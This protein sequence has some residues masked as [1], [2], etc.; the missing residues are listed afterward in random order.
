MSMGDGPWQ[1]AGDAVMSDAE[2]TVF[3]THESEYWVVREGRL[4]PADA[5]ELERIAERERER[6]A[7]GRLLR[8]ERERR[9]KARPA[10][11]IA[12]FVCWCRAVGLSVG[13]GN[14]ASADVFEGSG[15]VP[16]R[17]PS[18]AARR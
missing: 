1:P 9:R 17:H 14:H 11:V 8:W 13:R 6:T 3:L 16:S 7:Q 2:W 5:A 12:R 15:D 18:D 10:G 4:A